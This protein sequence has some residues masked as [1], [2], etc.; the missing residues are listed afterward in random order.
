M[1]LHETSSSEFVI[2]GSPYNLISSQ[3]AIILGSPDQKLPSRGVSVRYLSLARTP[4]HVRGLL[5]AILNV[6]YLL[7]QCVHLYLDTT[8]IKLQSTLSYGVCL[9]DKPDYSRYV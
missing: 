7:L 2:S 4:G 8:V 5:G 9:L 6:V 3:G 1:E